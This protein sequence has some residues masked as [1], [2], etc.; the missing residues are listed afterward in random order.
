ME[1]GEGG[2]ERGKDIE[3]KRKKGCSESVHDLGKMREGRDV[4][5][6]GGIEEG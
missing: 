1:A 2:N 3:E 6:E 5:M 4:L